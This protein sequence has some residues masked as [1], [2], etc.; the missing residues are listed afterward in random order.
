[1]TLKI[2]LSVLALLTA[3]WIN[4]RASARVI[5]VS[6]EASSGDGSEQVD[7]TTTELDIDLGEQ[8][9]EFFKNRTQVKES[10]DKLIEVYKLAQ[11]ENADNKI[12]ISNGAGG[13]DDPES[14]RERRTIFGSDERLPVDNSYRYP[15]CAVG[16]LDSGCTAAFIGPYHAITAA[17]CVYDTDT[18]TWKNNLNMW[19]R[20]TCNNRGER[21]YWSQVWSVTG[22][23]QDHRQDHDYALI[24]YDSNNP[25]PC[26]LP[27]GY[28][29]S[30][31]DYG[32]D[33]FGYPEDKQSVSG[34]SYASMWFT[35]CHF[36]DTVNFGRRYRFRCDILPGNSGSALYAERGDSSGRRV[37]YG[38]NTQQSSTW[39]YGNRL[40]RARFCR[41]VG[42]MKESGYTPMCGSTACCS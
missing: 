28:R 18:N 13:E 26:Y 40:D 5:H 20:R 19:R 42:W 7:N 8:A 34:C 1:M 3:V 39:N 6:F 21:M 23:T 14:P 25:S 9:V 32:F 31:P 38:V 12:E 10:F 15:Y 17:H 29:S 22:F 41:I 11:S 27:F 37:V 36:S 30:W 2:F 4:P 33:I 16:L 24:A 35:S